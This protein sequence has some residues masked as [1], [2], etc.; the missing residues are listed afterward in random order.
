MIRLIYRHKL[1]GIF[2]FTGEVPVM[3]ESLIT[4]PLPESKAI[5]YLNFDSKLSS[6]I[7]D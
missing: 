2:T 1:T 4:W 7:I 6:L 3:T 5:R